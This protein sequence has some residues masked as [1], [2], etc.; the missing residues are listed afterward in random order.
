VNFSGESESA[1]LDGPAAR[2]TD[3]VVL[4]T[5]ASEGIGRA[6]AIELAQHRLA[7]VLAARNRERLEELA[8]ECESRGSKA[9]A[10]PTDLVDPQQRRALVDAALARFGRL[11][12]LINN[13]GATMWSRLDALTDLAIFEQLMQINYLSAVHLTALA[14]PWLKRTRGR[15]VAV[16]SMAGFTGV[17]ERT[18][19]AASKHA[20]V[21]F[22]E[23]L[24]IELEGSGVTVTIIAPDFV[25]S[26]IH[27]RAIGPDGRPLGRS[28]MQQERIMSAEECARL[29]VPAIEQR[30]RLLIT[31]ARG[32][33]GRWLKL[34]APR[35][36]DRMA[37]SAIRNRR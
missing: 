5:G 21:G 25:R 27:K 32:R 33:L 12:A 7:L 17:P 31:S 24:R 29:I 6:L 26:E 2:L 30:E 4:L 22:F 20:M 36:V 37:A 13:A 35:L 8:R 1:S 9:L 14:L 10:V 18:G 15:L 34:V 16:A 28:P 19:Y 11:D 3:R 23:S